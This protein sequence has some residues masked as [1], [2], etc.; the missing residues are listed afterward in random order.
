MASFH[1]SCCQLRERTTRP[2]MHEPCS[3]DQRP[4]QRQ[5]LSKYYC[6]IYLTSVFRSV[7][8]TTELLFVSVGCGDGLWVGD[9]GGSRIPPLVPSASHPPQRA[10]PYFPMS[11]ATQHQ[12]P[13]SGEVGCGVRKYSDSFNLRIRSMPGRV[14]E[15]RRPRPVSDAA[16]WPSKA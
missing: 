2:G 4:K 10:E 14:N 8:T 1:G 5:K 16:A 11:P 6:Y 7:W 3:S 13:S 9:W 12:N 15:T